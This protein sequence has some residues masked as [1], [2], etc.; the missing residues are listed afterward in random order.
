M[1]DHVTQTHEETVLSEA[2]TE[3]TRLTLAQRIRRRIDIPAY[4]I[5]CVAFAI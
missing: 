4:L 3:E 5:A 2:V 1:E